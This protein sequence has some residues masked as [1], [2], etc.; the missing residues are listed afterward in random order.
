MSTFRHVCVYDS[1]GLGLLLAVCC[2]YVD[3]DMFVTCCNVLLLTPS[4]YFIARAFSRRVG[5]LVL[6]PCDHVLVYQVLYQV[7]VAG[8]DSIFNLS[9]A[10]TRTSEYQ[11][12][13]VLYHY[14]K[15]FL[16]VLLLLLCH[17]DVGRP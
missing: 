9:R 10:D 6:A 3:H 17:S 4:T 16:F 2:R 14:E 1:R 8:P 12:R 11:L 15:Y 7:V 13:V 5:C